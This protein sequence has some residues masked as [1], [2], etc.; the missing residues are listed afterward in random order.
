MTK[1]RAYRRTYYYELTWRQLLLRLFI[2]FSAAAVAL[3]PACV[4][5]LDR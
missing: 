4:A 3:F 5:V 1:K 2:L